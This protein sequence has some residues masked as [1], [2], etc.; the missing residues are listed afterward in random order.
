MATEPADQPEAAAASS[1]STSGVQGW[2]EQRAA[3]LQV[4]LE[5]VTAAENAELIRHLRR[6]RP[7]QRQHPSWRRPDREVK[8]QLIG[9]DILHSA[10]AGA[11]RG[12]PE[13]GLRAI[14]RE[15]LPLPRVVPLLLELWREEAA[16]LQSNCRGTGG[17][18]L[19]PASPEQS[20]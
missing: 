11:E 19:Q 2:H 5:V 6:K 9:W 15:P 4:P 8:K 10:E 3:W 20:S 12:L 1:A 14:S 17:P 7:P 18:A 16:Y 13:A